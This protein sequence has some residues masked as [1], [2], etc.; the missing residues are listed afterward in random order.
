MALR[1]VSTWCEE[2]PDESGFVEGEGFLVVDLDPSLLFLIEDDFEEPKPTDAAGLRARVTAL[3]RRI[4]TL[5]RD[6]EDPDAFS[7]A[8]CVQLKS[9]TGRTAVLCFHV[10]GGGYMGGPEYS[11]T[12]PYHNE[13]EFRASI[14]EAGGLTSLDD[15]RR[16]PD[17]EIAE[18]VFGASANEVE[19]GY[20]AE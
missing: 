15:L 10:Y 12:G 11:W 3:R 13:A 18:R 14:R 16:T 9:S 17:S 19:G 4:A 7:M 8:S 1:E 6:V 2:N 5:F 20:A